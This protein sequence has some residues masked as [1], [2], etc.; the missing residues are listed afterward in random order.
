MSVPAGRK[1]SPCG[2]QEGESMNAAHPPIAPAPGAEPRLR[3]ANR[4]A[5][6]SASFDKV[7]LYLRV[8][9]SLRNRIGQGDWAPEQQL[10]TID[11]LAKEYGVALITV[12]LALQL[13]GTEGL[14]ES[15]R[16]RGTFVKADVR[17]ANEAFGLHSAINDHLAMPENGSIHV[18]NRSFTRE[19]PAHF[20]P[21]GAQKYPEYAVIE[22]L[23][24]F[25]GEPFSYLRIMVARQIFEKFPPGADEKVKVLR[26]ILDQGRMKLQRSYLQIV[27]SYADERL[28]SLLECAPLS[29]LV[30]IRTSRVDTKGKVVLCHDAYYRGDKFVYEVEEEGVE[31]SKSSDLVLPSSAGAKTAKGIAKGK[32]RG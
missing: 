20:V 26:L 23:H 27:V 16:G 8:A 28:A 12:R 2:E 13:L 1:G 22:K 17:P 29:A 5:T 15:T 3:A 9:N 7:A 21:P 18:L 25:D 6:A 32:G 31:L 14:I 24:K 30:R 19:L 4:L 10:P 11:E